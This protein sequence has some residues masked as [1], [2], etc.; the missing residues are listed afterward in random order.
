MV[1]LKIQL[2]KDSTV[3]LS[4]IESSLQPDLRIWLAKDEV[5]NVGDKGVLRKVQLSLSIDEYNRLK[6][7][8]P[9]IDGLINYHVCTNRF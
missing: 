7:S 6:L 2:S 9:A 8:L 5:V 3:T 1:N 4:S